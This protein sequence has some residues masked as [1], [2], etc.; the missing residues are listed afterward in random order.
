MRWIDAPGLNMLHCFNA[1]EEDEGD[2]IVIVGS[3]AVKVEQ[4][5]E[6][7]ELAQLTIEKLRINVKSKSLE[8]RPLCPLPRI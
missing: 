2:T 4:V 5:L 3:N 1:W 7:I 6:R 8:R